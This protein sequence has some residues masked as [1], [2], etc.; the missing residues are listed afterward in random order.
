MAAAVPVGVTVHVVP[1]HRCA[2]G[3]VSPRLPTAMQ[4][5]T[6]QEMPTSASAGTCDVGVGTDF[7]VLPVQCPMSVPPVLPFPC[8]PLSQQSATVAQDTRSGLGSLPSPG[9]STVDQA[10]PFQRS[11]NVAGNPV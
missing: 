5:L 3:C 6:W 11:M 2:S 4:A 10:C 1:F 8:C 9:V 7:H